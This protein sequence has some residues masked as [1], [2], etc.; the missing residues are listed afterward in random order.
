[1]REVKSGVRERERQVIE[2]EEEWRKRERKRQRDV[3]S[4]GEKEMDR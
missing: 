4:G 1:M 2:M 3:L